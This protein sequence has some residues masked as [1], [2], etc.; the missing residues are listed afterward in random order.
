MGGAPSTSVTADATTNISTKATM[1]TFQSCIRATSG[2]QDVIIWGD[3]NVTQDITQ[4]MTLHVDANCVSETA[5]KGDFTTNVAESI[6]QSLKDVRQ[7]LLDIGDFAQDSVSSDI[8]Q[9]ITTDIGVK[10]AQ[11]CVTRTN[12]AQVF[13][14]KGSGNVTKNVLQRQTADVTAGCLLTNASAVD[15]VNKSTTTLNQKSDVAVKSPFDVF[16]DVFKNLF[17]SGLM[18]VLA[19]CMVVFVCVALFGFVLIKKGKKKVPAPAPV[20]VNT[21]PQ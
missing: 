17:D 12:G 14:I 5:Q 4:S 19:I 21:G 9:N 8:T 11:T 6:Q 7:G 13:L 10:S 18:G 1:S 3:G 20:I 16:G 2:S 15:S